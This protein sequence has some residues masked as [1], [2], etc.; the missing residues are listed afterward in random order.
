[1]VVRICNAWAVLA[2]WGRSPQPG[3][4]GGGHLLHTELAEIFTLTVRS[5]EEGLGFF[6]SLSS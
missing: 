1:M 2:L 4:Q 6:F 3:P 5:K